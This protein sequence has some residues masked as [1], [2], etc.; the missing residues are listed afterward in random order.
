VT[1]PYR[2]KQ[3]AQFWKGAVS[4]QAPADILPTRPRRYPFPVGTVIATAGSCFAQNVAKRLRG[5]HR[6]RMLFAEEVRDGQPCYSAQ[7][8]NIYTPRQL[9]QLMDEAFGK[10][11][12]CD[13]IVRGRNKGH[14]D[15]LRPEYVKDGF[16]SEDAVR[17]AR[18]T[19]LSAVRDVLTTCDIFVFTLGLTECWRSRR[20]GTVYPV[21]PGVVSD[22]I[23]EGGY[24]FHNFKYQE[25]VDDLTGVVSRFAEVNP[26][27]RIILTVSPVP[28]IATY[29]DEHVLVATCASKSIL[30]AACVEVEDRH[31]SLLYF[32]SYEIVTGPFSQGRYFSEDLRSVTPSAIDHVMKAFEANFLPE[33]TGLFSD[34]DA[35]VVCDEESITKNIGF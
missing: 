28:L 14:I 35:A 8:G 24:E 1:N 16:H 34:A 23:D 4:D 10:R 13:A 9:V 22:E 25:I 26:S 11:S 2:K 30:R 21:A 18:A 17:Q 15:L 20:D 31:P 6:V 29:T 12:P 19:H 27:A 3:T 7:Y 32:P 5:D 33:S